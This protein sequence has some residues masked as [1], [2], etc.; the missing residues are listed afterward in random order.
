MTLFSPKTT[1]SPL[2][3]CRSIVVQCI[4]WAVLMMSLATPA[5]ALTVDGLYQAQVSIDNQS[6]GQ[7]QGA[8]KIGFAQVIVKVTGQTQSLNH[9]RVRAALLN[10]DAYVQH[11]SF[12]TQTTGN[13]TQAVI[14]LAFDQPRIDQLLADSRLP[15]WGAERAAVLVWLVEEKSGQRHI[16][17][18]MSHPVMAQVSSQAQQRGMPLLWPLLDIEDQLNVD[19]GA[20][21]GLFKDQ[22]QLASARYQADAVL[23]GRMYQDDELKWQ[24]R[25]NFWLGDSEQ[26]WSAQG[27]QLNALVSP[28][29]DR[30]AASLVAKFAMPLAIGVSQDSMVSLVVEQVNSLDDYE[31]LQR[32]LR[33]LSGVRTIQLVRATGQTLEYRLAIEAS[34]SQ[35]KATLDLTRSLSSIEELE[36]EQT[37]GG[38]NRW[39]Y[40][41]H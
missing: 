41:W 36:V 40:E 24:L 31:A 10:T 16:I 27:H 23:V 7:V 34:A 26:Q 20:L 29:Q 18:D 30:L 35:I 11:F 14:E 22:I 5:V 1:T 6:A 13:E 8:K 37:D 15:V 4:L 19:A 17:N 12:A 33:G 2:Y 25:W 39:H 28:V 9:A 32:L 21:W 3:L 38:V